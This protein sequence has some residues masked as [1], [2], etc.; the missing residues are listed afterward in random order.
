MFVNYECYHEGQRP[1]FPLARL[2]FAQSS[3]G[4][5]VCCESHRIP[6]VFSLSGVGHKNCSLKR[7]IDEL[8]DSVKIFH[9]NMRSDLGNVLLCIAV[10]LMAALCFSICHVIQILLSLHPVPTSVV[11]HLCGSQ[12]YQLGL[13]I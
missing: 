6:F 7:L 5:S 9:K 8:Y 3:S 13:K 4:H 11:R 10:F 12:P 1:D 2:F